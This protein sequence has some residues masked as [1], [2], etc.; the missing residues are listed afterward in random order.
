MS[1]KK[2]DSK[3]P[4][5]RKL[6]TDDVTV[7][8]DG[9]LKRAV[10]AAAL[11]N[12]M[13][14]FDFGVYAYITTTI[15]QVFFPPGNDA[16]NILFTFGTF[17]AAFIVRPIGGAFFGPLGDRIGRQKVLALTM[18]LMAAGTLAI[19]LIPSYATIGLWAPV[20]LL[21]ARLLQGFSTGG[22]YGGAATFIAEYSP[23]KRRGFMGSWLEF[24]TL[25]GYVLGASL[26]TGLQLGMSEEAL[27]AWGW[28]IPFLIAGPLGL[29]GLY[30]RLKLEET[31]AFQKQQEEA[32][33]REHVKVPFV[34][35]FAENW[36]A[37]IV[38]IGLVLVFNVTDY[39]LLSYMPTYLTNTL[40]RSATSGL[41]LVIVVMVLMMIVITFSG[42]L[43]DR[44][45]RRPVLFAGCIGFLVLSWPA[46][47]LVQS[48][49]TPLVFVGLLVLG[50][51]LVTFTSTMPS[52]LPALFPTIIR[53]GALA[54]AFNVSVSL[55]GGT[56]PLATEA[57]VVWAE[58]KGFSWAHDIP[59]FY[60]MAA[61]V[62]GLVAVWFTK[63]TANEP[64]LGSGPSV[65]TDD[66][67]REL[68]EA[69]ADESSE[70][71]KSDWALEWAQSGLIDVVDPKAAE[72]DAARRR[73]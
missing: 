40:G 66:E 13:E 67:A 18:I 28:R 50:L 30:L 59:A 69:Y 61:A 47:K 24:G 49:S 6:T 33:G 65:A 32:A 8:E 3:S 1:A 21:L 38:C 23:D 73:G 7:V 56:T 29:I 54:I 68:V 17:T 45:G 42:R 10:S 55:F 48:E 19:G 41:L 11:G 43:S 44:F 58:G 51:V 31:P 60:L 46:L 36:R 25:A 72:A 35:L 37:L 53:Y 63:E 4:A 39:M 64:L 12:A 9:L 71:A 70:V 52:T 5:R 27:L 20:L 22:E 14:W 16:L 34:K 26:V 57:L 2:N 15:A 62:I